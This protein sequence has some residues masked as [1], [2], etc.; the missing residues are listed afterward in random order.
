MIDSMY[1]CLI[2]PSPDC[3]PR[4]F[5]HHLLLVSQLWDVVILPPDVLLAELVLDHLLAAVRGLQ[6]GIAHLVQGFYL[7]SKCIEI[8]SGLRLVLS[9]LQCH[10][11][12]FCIISK[13]LFQ[14]QLPILVLT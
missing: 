9:R 14:I 3:L 11:L 7:Q 13:A 1:T 10:F 4:R 2:N 5:E 12:G 8:T 6:A